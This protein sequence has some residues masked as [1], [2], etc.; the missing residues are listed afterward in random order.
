MSIVGPDYSRSP[1]KSLFGVFLS[2]CLFDFL[3]LQS[4]RTPPVEAAAFPSSRRP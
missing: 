2:L 1:V 4:M 3:V